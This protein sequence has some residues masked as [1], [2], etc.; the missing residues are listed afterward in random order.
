MHEEYTT[1][2]GWG[3]AGTG[4]G[5]K[6]NKERK[7]ATGKEK[8]KNSQSRGFWGHWGGGWAFVLSPVSV[9]GVF[10]ALPLGRA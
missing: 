7:K 4:D 5:R 3:G 2:G 8:G 10:A 6:D 9:T 1:P